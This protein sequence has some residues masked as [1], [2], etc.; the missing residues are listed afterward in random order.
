MQQVPITEYTDLYQGLTE[1][2][3]QQ[4]VKQGKTNKLKKVVGKSYLQIFAGN[5]FTF[6][7]LLGFIIFILMAFSA[8]RRKCCL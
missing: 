6:F 4:R 3:V 7:N 1:A 5:I 8:S 2:E